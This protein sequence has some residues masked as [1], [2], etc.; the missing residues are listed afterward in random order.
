M[1]YL[2]HRS[3]ITRRMFST[4]RSYVMQY[5]AVALTLSA[6]RLQT[7][8]TTKNT[9]V[10]LYSCLAAYFIDIKEN[11]NNVSIYVRITDQ[12][13][14]SNIRN[15]FT[16]IVNCLWYV[17]QFIISYIHE[18]NYL[19]YNFIIIITTYNSVKNQAYSMAVF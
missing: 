1:L 3:Y 15:K 13:F 17:L 6:V 14:T 8:L 11:V 19:N 10:R 7:L 12:I 4:N 5:L 16:K 18:L 9:I 2:Y